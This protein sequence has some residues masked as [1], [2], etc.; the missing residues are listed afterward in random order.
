MQEHPN[1]ERNKNNKNVA[2]VDFKRGGKFVQREDDR[3]ET[4]FAP[5]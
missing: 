2:T 4:F 1:A 5:Q 3:H